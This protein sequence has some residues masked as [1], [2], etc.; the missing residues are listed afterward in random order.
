MKMTRLLIGMTGSMG[1]LSM[2]TY[3]IALQQHFS[4][5]KIIMTQSAMQF[6]PKET[7]SMFANGIYV[8]EF[9]ISSQNLMHMELARWAQLF[10]ILPASANILAQAAHGLADTLLSTTILAYERQVIFFPNMN[11]TM[12]NNK[13]LQNNIRL[14][15]AGG[16]KVIKPLER[17]AFEYASREIEINHILPSVDS[18]ISILRLEEELNPHV[19]EDE[20]NK[21]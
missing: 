7:L 21:R 16:H 6:I 5:I 17:P 13:I 3:M 12:W 15:E 9:P 19:A 18:V 14:L 10:M 4:E 11:S 8:N 2:P 20:V 1:M